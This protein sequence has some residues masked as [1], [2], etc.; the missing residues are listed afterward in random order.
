MNPTSAIAAP[1]GAG[2]FVEADLRFQDRSL[3]GVSRTFALTVP[4]LPGRL[5]TVVG[6]AYLLCR[7]ADTIEDCPGLAMDDKRRLYDAFVRAVETG[8]GAEAF[9]AEAEPPIRAHMSA[10][11]REL[12]AN[13]PAVVRVTQGFRADEQAALLRCLR[14]MSDGMERFQEGAFAAGLDDMAHLSCYCYHVAGVVGEM[15]TELFCI[16]DPAIAARREAL[17]PFAVAFGEGLQLTNI[18]KDIWDDKARG[19]CWLPRDVFARHGFDLAAFEPGP[20]DP[21]FRAAYGEVLAEAHGKLRDAM[22]YT[23]RI[24]R[25]AYG[26]RMFCAWAVY[27]AALTLSKLASDPAFAAGKNTK[28]SRRDVGRVVL[29]CKAAGWSDTLLRAGFGRCAAG[30]PPPSPRRD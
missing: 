5:R 6:N 10:A 16:H 7:I 30:A 26:V 25:R 8:A 20:M 27:M 22:D 13:A 14:V 19:V 3:Q 4:Q 18:L 12:I 21:R 28:I 23:L 17:A 15:L 9:A 2:R 11:E 29:Y 1:S 24:P